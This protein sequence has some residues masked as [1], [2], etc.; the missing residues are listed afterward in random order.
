ML[1][2]TFYINDR[3]HAVRLYGRNISTN[4]KYISS[5]LNNTYH[6][7][8]TISNNKS[9]KYIWCVNH[10][11]PNNQLKDFFKCCIIASINNYTLVIPPLFPHYGNK[12]RGVQWFDH[13]YDLKQFSHVLNFVTLD[14][15]LPQIK[16]NEKNVMIDCYIQQID[17]VSGRTWYSKNT[18]KSIE[19][20][21]KISIDFHHLVNLSSNFH[22]SELF[23]K[24]RTCS[25]IFLH[26]HYTTFRQFFLSSNIY[27]QR[28]F[29]HFHRTP[30]IQRM[31]SQLIQLL[32]KLTIGK[33][34][35]QTSLS[36]LAVVHMRI[37]DHNVMNVSTYIKQI[38]YLINTGVRFTHLHIMCPY[39]NSVDIKQFTHSLPVPFTISQHLL[40]HVEF[41]LDRYLFDVLEQEI[42]YQ[43]PIFLA[44]PWTTYSATVLM[45]KVYQHKG[46]VYVFSTAH[47]THP[48][49]VTKKNAKYFE[50]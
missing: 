26:I 27:M 39:L 46:T 48:F 33:K 45:Q 37:G 2:I 14:Q 8:L 18:L 10:Y 34:Q 3:A 9:S 12:E 4:P 15:F 1:S 11:G 30:L 5:N 20:Y 29:Q 16:I 40:N 31:T 25:S 13:F 21:Y 49:L 35:S 6:G 17:L 38:L 42:A 24:A 43:A 23:S 7:I 50:K 19:N 47:N 44:S 28:I 36:N 22:L 32:P 41:I